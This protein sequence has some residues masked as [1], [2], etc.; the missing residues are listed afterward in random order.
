[1][2]IQDLQ[3][4]KLFYQCTNLELL[5]EHMQSP[6]KA[7]IG[8]DCTADSL[9]IGSMIQLLAIRKLQQHDHIP[10]IILGS[11]TTRIGD[12]S[13]KNE[14]RKM[15]SHEEIEYNKKGVLESINKFLIP[16]KKAIILDNNSWLSELKYTEFL[17]DMGTMFSVNKMISFDNVKHRLKQGLNLSF[18]EF[19]YMILQGYDFWYLYKNYDCILQI[20]GSDQWANIVNG[21]ELVKKREGTVVFGLT[22]TL[23]TNH[24]NKK[25]GKTEKGA[26][27]LNE[28]KLPVYSFWQYFRNMH[29]QDCINALYKLT[30]LPIDEIQRLEKLKGQALNEAKHILATEVT[31]LCHGK[32]KSL[33]V[34]QQAKDNFEMQTNLLKIHIASKSIQLVD[35][36]LKIDHIESKSVAK[37]L[38]QSG[39]V[40]LNN[41]VVKEPFVNITENTV[42]KVSKK[43]IFDIIFTS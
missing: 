2:L 7:Y 22:T 35:L 28:S 8:F 34:A 19:N 17:G 13:G 20:G 15:L 4:R 37:R 27:W 31:E 29:D 24:L 43:H 11:A 36:V 33:S 32:E 3:S 18:L 9:H 41:I 6:Q 26:V 38:I 39:A 10:I 1:M 21:V 42:L 25:M 14:M 5:K 40:K 30:E 23:L 12:P 16:G